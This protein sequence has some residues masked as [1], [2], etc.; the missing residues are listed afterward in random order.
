VTIWAIC[1]NVLDLHA[2]V[3][4]AETVSTIVRTDRAYGSSG[5]RE[6]WWIW[7]GT[8][9]TEGEPEESATLA[10][11]LLEKC[12][13][14]GRAEGGREEGGGGGTGVDVGSGKWA[15]FS[16]RDLK[17]AEG[18]MSEERF[19]GVSGPEGD[20][21]TAIGG[22]MSGCG[23]ETTRRGGCQ[24]VC[25]RATRRATGYLPL[26]LGDGRR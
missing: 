23:D 22:S 21:V 14:D 10:I 19:H 3:S 25:G 2:A 20:S 1:P 11:P 13:S 16:V 24:G 15:C 4:D 8:T 7:R 17:A 26:G 12:A 9:H 5:Y 18:G 6:S